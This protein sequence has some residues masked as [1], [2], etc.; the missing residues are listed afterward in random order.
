[1][2]NDRGDNDNEN[3]NESGSLPAN[4]TVISRVII[5][6]SVSSGDDSAQISIESPTTFEDRF[7]TIETLLD[8][9]EQ[10]IVN[11]LRATIGILKHE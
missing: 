11:Q 6:L 3:I 5:N 9:A 8:V 7:N 1:M 10:R 2:S 4:L